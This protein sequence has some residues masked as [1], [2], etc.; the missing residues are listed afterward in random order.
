MRVTIVGTLPPLKGISPYCFELVRVLSKHVEV[1]F[2]GF[3]SLYPESL[4]PGGTRVRDKGYD[5]PYLE[6]VV[7]RNTLAWY[8]PFSWFWAGLTLKGELVHAQWWAYPLAFIYFAVLSIAK[9][10]KRRIIITVHNVLPHEKS[11]FKKSLDSIVLSLGDYFIVHTDK[12]KGDLAQL[13]GI[14]KDRIHIVPHGV[15]EPFPL[16]WISKTEA[17]RR[18]GI[19]PDKRVILHFGNI[20]DYKGLDILIESLKFV[21]EE[22]SDIA[23]LIAGKPWGNWEKYER[24]IERFGVS[25]IVIKRLDFIPP[26]EVE[27]YFS[28]SDIVVLPYKYFDSQSGIGALSLPFEKPLIVTHVGGLA[29]FVKDERAIARPNHAE[30]LGYKIIR[31]LKDEKLLRKLSRDSGDLAKKYSWDHISE[32]TINVYRRALL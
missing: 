12:N 3:K 26:S 1:E 13:Y 7:T 24:L 2:V 22:V 25:D 11:R 6:K 14:S 10:R 21:K 23:I 29:D 28:A 30:D 20:R 16:R 18:L 32:K 9:L 27:F 31:A 5:V 19:P 4:Y 17:R 8:D 15:L